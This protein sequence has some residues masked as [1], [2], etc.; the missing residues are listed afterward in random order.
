MPTMEMLVRCED[1]DDVAV[2]KQPCDAV[3]VTTC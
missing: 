1:C 3:A 2:E